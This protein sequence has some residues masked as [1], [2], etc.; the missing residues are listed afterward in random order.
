MAKPL[1]VAGEVDAYCTSCRMVLNHRIIS[2]FAGKPHQVHC[3]T[4]KKDH[5]YK[6]RAPG[7]AAPAGR[8]GGGGSAPRSARTPTVT[9]AQAALNLREQ[10][11][12]KAVNGRGVSEFK[13]YSVK[14]VF[15]A[16][17]VIR[18]KTF[19]D[20]VVTRVIDAH[21]I[22]VLFREEPKTL[23]HGMV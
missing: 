2:M 12:M 5:R 3:L 19:G 20:G 22:E 13:P 6:A 18:H 4:C 16:G 9:R 21:K 14:A 17:D 15:N 1:K 8:A 10:T 23:A 11:W 7:D